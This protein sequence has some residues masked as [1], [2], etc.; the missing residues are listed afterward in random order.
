[1]IY[2]I[3]LVV[4]LTCNA[5]I[6]NYCTNPTLQNEKFKEYSKIFYDKISELK[7]LCKEIAEQLSIRRYNDKLDML[8]VLKDNVD[9]AFILYLT[10]LKGTPNSNPT[11]RNDKEKEYESQYK[12]FIDTVSIYK[13]LEEYLKKVEKIRILEGFESRCSDAV[14]V[15]YNSRIEGVFYQELLRYVAGL[16][17][18]VAIPQT[19]FSEDILCDSKKRFDSLDHWLEFTQKA[20]IIA[21]ELLINKESS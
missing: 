11:K 9:H 6:V 2:N 10:S 5:H 21:Q 14:Q 4:Y 16:Y 20:N 15:F 1:M 13:D 7:T 18:E 8:S 3:F 19:N 12:I 17:A